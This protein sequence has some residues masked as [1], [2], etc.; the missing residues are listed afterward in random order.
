VPVP[1]AL[2]SMVAGGIQTAVGC[3]L[4]LYQCSCQNGSVRFGS[5]VFHE[6]KVI[7]LCVQCGTPAVCLGPLGSVPTRRWGVFPRKR[8]SVYESFTDNQKVVHLGSSGVPG[9]SWACR[10]SSGVA[11][12]ARDFGARMHRAVTDDFSFD[13][14]T[15]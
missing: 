9:A 10:V 1:E 15:W 5:I 8:T 7:H 14:K 12:L 2:E 11:G 4:E 3:V 6:R 13:R